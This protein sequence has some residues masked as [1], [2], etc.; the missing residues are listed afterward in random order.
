MLCRLLLL[1]YSTRRLPCTG[2]AQ[3][4]M[5]PQPPSLPCRRRAKPCVCCHAVQSHP[6]LPTPSRDAPTKCADR[7]GLACPGLPTRRPCDNGTGFAVQRQQAPR[8]AC[9]T[10]PVRPRNATPCH[11]CLPCR[12][13]LFRSNRCNPGPRPARTNTAMPSLPG[14]N[15]PILGT[16]SLDALGLSKP[17]FACS[18][19]ELRHRNLPVHACRRR[20]AR[21][22]AGNFR[23]GS[24]RAS[25]A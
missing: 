22:R 19:R 3:P 24:R 14:R 10:A 20:A 23:D 25:P 8:R 18:G 7:P 5:D 21:C 9:R 16:T 15:S 11:P 17:R 6:C 1:R 12:A 2:R 4:S 13:M